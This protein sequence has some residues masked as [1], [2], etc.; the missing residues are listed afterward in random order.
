MHIDSG[1]VG[2]NSSKEALTSFFHRTPF[3][4]APFLHGIRS[5]KQRD[6]FAKKQNMKRQDSKR[7]RM[8][9]LGMLPTEKRCQKQEQ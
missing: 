8:T 3:S 5:K 6:R 4:V 9:F 2:N 7:S 1:V